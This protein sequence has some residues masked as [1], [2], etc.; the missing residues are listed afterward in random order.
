MARAG[1]C[2]KIVQSNG[3]AVHDPKPK[4]VLCLALLGLG[5]IAG[6]YGLVERARIGNAPEAIVPIKENGFS[7]PA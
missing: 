7:L 4:F 1:K 6:L 2:L 3:G 5:L